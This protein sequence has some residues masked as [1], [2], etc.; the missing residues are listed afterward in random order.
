M[1]VIKLR[2]RGSSTRDSTLPV[3]H[4][5]VRGEALSF[6]R[7]PSAPSSGLASAPP[8]LGERSNLATVI[9][10]AVVAYAASSVAHELVGHGTGCLVTGVRPLLFTSIILQSAG[11]NRIVDVSGPV[12]NILFGTGA[13]LFFQRRATF[14]AFSYFL[15]LFAAFNLLVA[16]GYLFWSGL[17]NW[18]D[19][20][21]LIRGLHPQYAWRALI[22]ITGAV[23]YIAVV[24]LLA[25]SLIRLVNA[26]QVGRSDVRR[27][28]FPAYLTSGLL[29]V[30]SAAFNRVSPR[31]IWVNGFSGSFL[32]FLGLLRLPSIV[33]RYAA[34]AQQGQP[35]RFS[36]AWAVFGGFVAIVFIFVL[37]PGI[38]L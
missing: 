14:T 24:R 33:D 3:A 28:I 1:T 26:G 37:G 9:A 18:G 38:R 36:L 32:A 25:R 15:F 29:A 4:C 13:F 27:L 12:A 31:L 11:G 8:R 21:A 17:T 16:T 20:A 19:W 30:A 35:I 22:G 7:M 34:E 23:L 2:R 6:Y 5:S 10:V